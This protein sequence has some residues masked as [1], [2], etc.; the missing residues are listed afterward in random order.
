M[1]VIF[2]LMFVLREGVEP[3]LFKDFNYDLSDFLMFE[4][5]SKN[6]LILSIF[7][8]EKMFFFFKQVIISPEFDWYH[9]Q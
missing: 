4:R 3:K 2:N 5:F 6:A 9:Y 8:L 1:R 7:E